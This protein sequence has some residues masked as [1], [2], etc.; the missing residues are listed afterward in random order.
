ML[1]F[2]LEL[3][4]SSTCFSHEDFRCV[5]CLTV[6]ILTVDF[7]TSDVDIWMYLFLLC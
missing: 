1:A 4:F 2:A 6:L 3:G 5:Y 7:Q